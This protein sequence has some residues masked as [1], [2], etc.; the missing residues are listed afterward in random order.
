M[1]NTHDLSA[2][3]S[4]KPLVTKPKTAMGEA[5]FEE[6]VDTLRDIIRMIEC[7]PKN[8]DK[9]LFLRRELRYLESK[10]PQ[11]TKF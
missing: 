5:S 7:I 8:A 4:R 9:I 6:R 1:T 3:A 10:S 11:N 2:A